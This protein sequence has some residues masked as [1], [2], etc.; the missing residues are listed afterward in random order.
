MHAMC[1]VEDFQKTNKL[2]YGCPCLSS[3]TTH[4]A[5]IL[6]FVCSNTDSFFSFIQSYVHV[7]PGG[8]G[9]T[10]DL[11]GWGATGPQNAWGILRVKS[12]I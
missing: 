5:Y 7:A 10:P 1:V 3:S 9:G 6:P 4:M 8:G 11:I 2:Q 12:G